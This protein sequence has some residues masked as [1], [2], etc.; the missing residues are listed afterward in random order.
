MKGV[1]GIET[2]SP[3]PDHALDRL[4]ISVLGSIGKKRN[5]KYFSLAIWLSKNAAVNARGLEAGFFKIH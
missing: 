2:N 1:R 3:Q 5:N 4:L